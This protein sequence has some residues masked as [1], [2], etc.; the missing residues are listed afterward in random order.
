MTSKHKRIPRKPEPVHKPTPIASVVSGFP[1][2]KNIGL[3]HVHV[4]DTMVCDIDG[5]HGRLTYRGYPIETLADNSSF[6]ETVFLLLNGRMPLKEELSSLLLTMNKERWLPTSPS[7][8]LSRLRSDDQPTDILQGYVAFLAGYDP[9][10]SVQ[11]RES[12]IRKAIRLVSKMGSAVA[13]WARL[14]EGK[15]PVPS[16]ED[17][18]HAANFLY[19]LTGEEPDPVKA[20]VLDTCLRDDLVGGEQT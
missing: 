1:V 9:E 17:L 10:L 8:S 18:S 19:M 3:R 5:T 20:Q 13:L 16:R 2:I 7:A 4:A 15:E 6:E 12:T 11:N 14:R